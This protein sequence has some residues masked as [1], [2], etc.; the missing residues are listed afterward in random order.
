[1]ICIFYV[2]FYIIDALSYMYSFLPLEC[3]S[4]KMPGE[5]INWTCPEGGGGPQYQVM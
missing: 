1:M 5:Y 2:L 3:C 4:I